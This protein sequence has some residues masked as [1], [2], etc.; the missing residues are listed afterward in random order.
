MKYAEVL[1]NISEQV[2]EMPRANFGLCQIVP[3]YRATAKQIAK[4]FSECDLKIVQAMVRAPEKKVCAGRP[5][6]NRARRDH[7]T[8]C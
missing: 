3:P 1:Q 8:G 5:A 2:H 4:A 6:A 7:A